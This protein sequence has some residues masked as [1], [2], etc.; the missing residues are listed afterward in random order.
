M[1]HLR[2]KLP[3]RFMHQTI[4][5]DCTVQN[6]YVPKPSSNPTDMRPPWVPQSFLINLFPGYGRCPARGDSSRLCGWASSRA[7]IHLQLGCSTLAPNCDTETAPMTAAPILPTGRSLSYRLRIKLKPWSLQ[8]NH[9][10]ISS[11]P[12]SLALVAFCLLPL[13]CGLLWEETRNVTLW[14][15]F[16]PDLPLTVDENILWQEAV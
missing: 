11:P 13:T 9:L 7:S 3:W 14:V 6:V 10:H 5:S 8:I 16:G 4:I 12:K 15:R 1:E 2:F